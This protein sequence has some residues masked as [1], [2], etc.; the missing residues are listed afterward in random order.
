MKGKHKR[1][2]RQVLTRLPSLAGAPEL[3]SLGT[4]RSGQPVLAKPLITC[5]LSGR[6]QHVSGRDRQPIDVVCSP[7]LVALNSPSYLAWVFMR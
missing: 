3:K 7:P 2:Q 1:D 6:S 4:F 5:H